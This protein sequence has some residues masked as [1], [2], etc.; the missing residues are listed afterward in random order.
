MKKFL[1]VLIFF[2]SSLSLSPLWS[3]GDTPLALSEALELALENNE[4]ISIAQNQVD[5]ARESVTQARSNLL[6]EITLRGERTQR[7]ET[8]GEFNQFRQEETFD[9]GADLV[10][11]LYEGG[12][13][14]YGLNVSQ[15]Q[16]EESKSQTYR[17]SQEILFQV[18][19][20]FYNVVLAGQ[21][22]R[23]A[24]NTLRRAEDQLNQAQTRY[25][26]G[27]VTQNS[28][29][30]AQVD[31]SEA[32]RQLEEAQNSRTNALEALAVELGQPETPEELQ[33][34]D[35]DTLVNK[36]VGDYE[37]QAKRSRKD[38]MAT[39]ARL[40]Q[41]RERVKFHK[42]DWYPSLDLV[43]SYDS[44]HGHESLGLE[45]DW[46]ATIQGSYP[47][48]SGWRET[49][50]INEAKVELRSARQQL[51]R[52]QQ[53][54]RRDVRQAYSTV[55]TQRAVLK[56][57]KDQVQ[58]ARRNYEEISA[59]FEEGLVDSVD[60]SDALTTLNESELRLARARISLRLERIRLKLATGTF[61]QKHLQKN[62]NS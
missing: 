43:A 23:I 40:T 53:E 47:L 26:V 37:N 36:P 56:S 27:K 58:S 45:K 35:T 11:P 50:Q 33:V 57:I 6:P 28:V 31:V 24:E 14:L 48:F 1:L 44:F 21:N 13:N 4:N 60:V 3:Q 39:K 55:E 8:S 34:P 16:L 9:W 51:Q 49:S 30:R 19:R 46:R 7:K 52:L 41:S 61:S 54:I 32:E 2:G 20:T 29:L 18:S 12:K 38:L 62:F 22:I 42:A 5:S 17:R 59:Q 25:D 10:Q 15:N